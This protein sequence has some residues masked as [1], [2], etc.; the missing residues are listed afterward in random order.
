M[1]GDGRRV[2]SDEERVRARLARAYGVVCGACGK[3]LAE[4]ETVWVQRLGVGPYHSGRGAIYGRA[5]VCAAYASPAFRAEM[6]GTEP[7]GCG[8]CGRRPYAEVTPFSWLFR[9]FDTAG[10]LLSGQWLR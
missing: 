10:K 1:T 2:L 5:P 3:P 7:K 9:H 6:E 8:S 4:G